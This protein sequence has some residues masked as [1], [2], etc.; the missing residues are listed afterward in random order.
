M[1]LATELVRIDVLGDRVG[2]RDKDPAVVLGRV[3]VARDFPRGAVA[4]TRLAQVGHRAGLAGR[5]AGNLDPAR[6]RVD[7]ARFEDRGKSVGGK[8]ITSYSAVCVL[9]V[10]QSQGMAAGVR[11]SIIHCHFAITLAFERPRLSAVFEA[12]VGQVVLARCA[13]RAGRCKNG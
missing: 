5:D 1:A 6:K 4:G 9:A 10:L 13:S 8:E 7:V 12:G 3:R 11:Y 2:K